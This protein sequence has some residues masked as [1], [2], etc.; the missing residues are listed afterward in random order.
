ML[1]QPSSLHP[2]PHGRESG[3]GGEDSDPAFQE[4]TLPAVD[5]G[6]Q[7]QALDWVWE[8]SWAG[9]PGVPSKERRGDFRSNISFEGTGDVHQC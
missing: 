6:Q 3:K 7:G 5:R 2:T 8:G 9:V 4:T 1:E